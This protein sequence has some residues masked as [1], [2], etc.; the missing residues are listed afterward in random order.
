MGTLALMSRNLGNE[1]SISFVWALSGY[2]VDDD[3]IDLP[4]KWQGTLG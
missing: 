2:G 4:V 3:P 1:K